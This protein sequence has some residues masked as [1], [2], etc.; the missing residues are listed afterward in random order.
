MVVGVR[1]GGRG[2]PAHAR[3]LEVADALAG[4]CRSERIP[5]LVGSLGEAGVGALLSAGLEADPDA[6]LTAVCAAARQRLGGGDPVIG[7]GSAAATL[8]EA[9]R[10]L[11][12]AQQVAAAAAASPSAGQ[13]RAY[14][15]PGHLRGPRPLHP[16]VRDD[17]HAAVGGRANGPPLRPP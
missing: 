10:S 17:P 16:P 1:P 9:R 14:H 13:G 15:R 7:A 4:A 5:A 12:E 11:L 8:A 3:M 6:V 2:L